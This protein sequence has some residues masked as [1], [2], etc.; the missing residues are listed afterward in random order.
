MRFSELKEKQVININN[1]KCLGCTAALEF[2]P[3]SGCISKIY[4]P[5]HGKFCNFPW[6]KA[7]YVIDFCQIKQIGPDVVLVDICE[8]ASFVDGKE[9]NKFDR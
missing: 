1:C 2:D 7:E 9:K 8:E 6:N 3:C 5:P 4:V